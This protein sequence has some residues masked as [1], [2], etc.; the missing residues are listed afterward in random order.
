MIPVPM[1][2][3]LW[4]GYNDLVETRS[5]GR[6]L[7]MVTFMLK[8]T[9]K[10]KAIIIQPK[11]IQN[12]SEFNQTLWACPKSKYK[13]IGII[14]TRFRVRLLKSQILVNYSN[15]KLLKRESFFQI[16]LEPLER[17]NQPYTQVI[18]HNMKLL[19]IS[20]HRMER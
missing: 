18:I 11:L 9:S 7:N 10:L 13:P 4:Y 14:K 1:V 3:K 12:S 19:K 16:N 5:E 2:P 20:N 17:R 6:L 8:S 15:L